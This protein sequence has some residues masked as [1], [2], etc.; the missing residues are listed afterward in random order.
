MHSW[1][2]LLLRCTMNAQA[3]RVRSLSRMSSG[4]ALTCTC[5]Y[6]SPLWFYIVRLSVLR[7]ASSQVRFQDR[8]LRYYVVQWRVEDLFPSL[9]HHLLVSYYGRPARLRTL[10]TYDNSGG[11]D[12]KMLAAAHALARFTILTQGHRSRVKRTWPL[13]HTP[14]APLQTS[15]LVG[16]TGNDFDTVDP[17]SQLDLALATRRDT[18]FLHN[19][20]WRCGSMPINDTNIR[21]DI[22]IERD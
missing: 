7:L 20:L 4:H 17:T 11:R 16:S 1:V 15:E 8:W 14:E 3:L 10:L 2:I 18:H 13:Y 5:R 19:Q 6:W 12:E 9:G 22:D 21:I